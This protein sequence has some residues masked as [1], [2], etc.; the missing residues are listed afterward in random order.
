M[1]RKSPKS[2]LNTKCRQLLSPSELWRRKA[3]DTVRDDLRN[4]VL[5]SHCPMG[6]RTAW[7]CGEL[8]VTGG[9]QTQTNR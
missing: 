7:E 1:G 8:P 2:C 5:S 6:E 4:N 3:R 9:V